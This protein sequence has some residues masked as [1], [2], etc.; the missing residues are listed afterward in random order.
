M[1]PP[2]FTASESGPTL[3]AHDVAFADRVCRRFYTQDVALP[4]HGRDLSAVCGTP[5]PSVRP[6]AC[7]RS[8]AIDS[9][10]VP[11]STET[12]STPSRVVLTL[13]PPHKATFPYLQRPHDVINRTVRPDAADSVWHGLPA[14]LAIYIV[15]DDYTIPSPT[16][17][18]V[19]NLRPAPAG[20]N[21][22]SLLLFPSTLVVVR[23]QAPDFFLRSDMPEES[24]SSLIS[25]P[26]RSVISYATST[27]FFCEPGEVI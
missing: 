19:P 8:L 15:R 2:N 26:A 7:E 22:R 13:R 3:G 10:T 24:V 14:V 9:D 27:F 18:E 17:V 12:F 4:D 23:R 20:N 16:S 1:S 11:S 21:D 6:H 25:S 5:T